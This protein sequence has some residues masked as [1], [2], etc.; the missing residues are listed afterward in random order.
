MEGGGG[1]RSPGYAGALACTRRAHS[2]AG[3]R[4]LAAMHSTLRRPRIAQGAP[5]RPALYTVNISFF[6]G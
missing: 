4:C 3:A 1:W 6:C 2:R 5:A